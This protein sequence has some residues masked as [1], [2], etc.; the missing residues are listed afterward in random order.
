MARDLSYLEPAERDPAQ[1]RRTG[2]ILTAVMLVGGVL[3]IWAYLGKLRAQEGDSRPSIVQ[4]LTEKFG[5]RDQN[6]QAFTTE[7]LEGNITLLTPLDGREKKRMAQSLRMMKEVAEKFPNDKKLRFVGITVNPEDDSPAA[8]KAMLDELG[9]GEDQRWF[10]LQAEEKN[11]RGYLRHKIRLETEE[12]IPSEDKGWTRRFRSTIVF[13]DESLHVLD[14]KFDFNFADEVQEESQRTL[15][16]A[17]ER[18]DKYNAKDHLDDLAKLEKR[19]YEILE[20][21]RKGDLKEGTN[22]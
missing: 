16:D 6:S 15:R 10:F 17:P 18:A 11:A 14:P 9:V 12:K 3:I 8:L 21:I 5:A 20:H 19:L 2:L 7:D 1:L 13:I 22:D 4:R